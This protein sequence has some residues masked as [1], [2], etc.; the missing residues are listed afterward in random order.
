MSNEVAM[1]IQLL[2]DDEPMAIPSIVLQEVL[3]GVRT[4]AAFEQLDQVLTGFPILF[5]TRETHVAAARIRSRCRANGI[6]AA[7]VDCLIAAHTILIEG[8]LFTTDDD[9][10]R[11]AKHNALRL[12]SV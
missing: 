2:E 8:E 3:S 10:K 5:A 1:F 11:I 6:A 12:F 9:F 4:D 7:T